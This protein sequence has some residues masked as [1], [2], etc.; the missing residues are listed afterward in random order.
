[1]ACRPPAAETVASTSPESPVSTSSTRPT[2][3]GT[4]TFHGAALASVSA[5]DV[6]AV[7]SPA[8]TGDA[9]PSDADD[10]AETVTVEVLNG[11]R[12]ALHAGGLGEHRPRD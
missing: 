5:E 12:A 11:V 2:W 9:R 4:S 8:L 1:M 3:T 6:T 7:T 10:V